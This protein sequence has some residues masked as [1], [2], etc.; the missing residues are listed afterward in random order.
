[1][2]CKFIYKQDVFALWNNLG[3]KPKERYRDDGWWVIN[4]ANKAIA[5]LAQNE[6]NTIP[7]AWYEEFF[8]HALFKKKHYVLQDHFEIQY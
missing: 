8:Q 2:S 5:Q 3:F 7:Y 4:Q 6:R 1:M